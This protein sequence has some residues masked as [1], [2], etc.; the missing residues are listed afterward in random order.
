MWSN[1]S[2]CQN[3]TKFAL[4]CR[5]IELGSAKQI[6]KVKTLIR[7]IFQKIGDNGFISSSFPNGLFMKKYIYTTLNFIEVIVYKIRMG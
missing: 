1:K 2:S 5:N 3:T 7:E 6:F 4:F